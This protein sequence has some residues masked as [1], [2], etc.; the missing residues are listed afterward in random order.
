MKR[1]ALWLV[2][3]LASLIC[4]VPLAQAQS[5]SDYTQGVDVSGST[6]TIWFK[7]TSSTTTWADT[8]YQLNGG[9]TQSLRMTFNAATGRHEQNVLTPVA[10]GNTLVYHFTYNKGAPAYDT[11]NFNFT[12]G[13]TGG[14]TV[15]TPTFSPAPGTYTS[16][17]SVTLAT[18]TAGAQIRYTTD[19][20]TPTA[21]SALYGGPINVAVTT[22]VKAIGIAGGMTNS[23]VATGAYTINGS[24][25]GGFSFTN[26]VDLAGTT[27]TIWFQP[28][29]TISF[30]D[31]HYTINGGP[32]QNFRMPQVGARYQQAVANVATGQVISHWFTYS[33][34]G[35]STVDTAKFS[36]TVGSTGG[37]AVAT[38][39]FNPAPGTY[40]TAQNVTITTST[41]GATIKY[42]TDGSTPTAASATYTGAVAI[43]STKTLKAIA[44]KAGMT[45]S[46]VASGLY[47]INVA[48]TVATPVFTPA[49]GTY[50]GAQNVTITSATAGA[51]IKYTTDGTNPTAASATYTG[52]VAIA[53]TKTLKAIAQKA[54][55]TDSAI[56]SGLYTI[57]TNTGTWNGMT[58]FNIVN[59]TNGKWADSQVF[60]SIIGKDWNTGNFVHVDLN[61]NL[62]PMSVGD[63]GQLTKNGQGYS[64]YFFSLAQGK[65]VT[66]PAINSARILLSVGGPMYIQV[67]V[68]GNGKIG[69]AGANIENPADPN[70]D[71]IFDFGEMAILPKGNPA[72]GIFVNTTRV[73]QYGFPVKLRVQGLN[74]YDQTVG[75]P[76]TEGRD[77]L[78]TKFIAETPAEFRGLA[79]TPYA[80]FRIMAPAH[81]TF[82]AGQANANYLQPYID[83]VWARYRNED[84]VFT[85]ENLGTF[86]GRVVGD[87]FTFTGGTQNGSFFINGKPTTSMALLGNGFLDDTSGGP[88]NAGTQLQIQAQ[89][90]AALNRHVVEQPANWH[91]AAAFYPAG[92]A[93]NWFA[94]FWHD[95]GINKLAYGFAYDDVGNFSPSLHTDSPTIVTFTIGW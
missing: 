65:S 54:G 7:P 66:I 19:G 61:G 32:Q 76:L 78:F 68:D 11:P 6:A 57:Q 9:P 20:S 83:A 84:L 64:N 26:G 45:D 47:T 90:C 8:H 75:E 55:S 49:P 44:Q 56:A 60:W 40:T 59:Q 31:V 30:V 53:T 69:Y 87:R 39:A 37:G 33:L 79:Q 85:L 15:A 22:T 25:G 70:I 80:P 62:V 1:L 48:T 72:Q 36:Y 13:S 52:P 42:T 58:T 46:A 27:A 5:A 86:R 73:D 93:A 41:A 89:M 43:A 35:A 3:L 88:T 28:S 92:T 77:A 34:T 10:A 21:A 95:H 81:A 74:G 17:Q 18:A 2:S 82:T 12:V 38:P 16:A 94:K 67:N 23:A 50:T 14:G 4:L 24:T 71:V 51:T 91:N 29:Q 63:N